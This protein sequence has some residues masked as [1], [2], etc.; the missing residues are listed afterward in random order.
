M[1]YKLSKPYTEK[2]KID[3]IVKYNHQKNLAIKET[4]V[5]L[6]ALEEN[7]IIKNGKL[8]ININYEKEQA[9]IQIK[10]EIDKLSKQLTELDTKRIRAICEPEIK[11]EETGETWLDYYNSKIKALRLQK[12]ELEE[13]M[14]NDITI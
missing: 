8:V 10:N 12:Q 11:E 6:Y 1:S 13:R 4:P 14:K 3:F 7:E 9:E 5:A 2:Q